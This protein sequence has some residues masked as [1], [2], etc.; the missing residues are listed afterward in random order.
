LARLHFEAG[1]SIL[2]QGQPVEYLYMIGRGRVRVLRD[3]RAER[4][5]ALAELGPGDHFG[6][7]ELV[8]GGAALASIQAAGDSPVDLVALPRHEV[9][10]ILHDLPQASEPLAQTAEARLRHNQGTARAA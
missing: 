4:P 3:A 5:Q 6:E 9:N 7:V 1:A 10:R 8:S 2:T